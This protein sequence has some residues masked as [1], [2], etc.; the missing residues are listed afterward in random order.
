V[1][2]GTFHFGFFFPKIYFLENDNQ[3][4]YRQNQDY[5]RDLSVAR[6]RLDGKEIEVQKLYKQILEQDQTFAKS[7]RL[8]EEAFRERE[9]KMILK[10]INEVRD[11]SNLRIQQ[12]Q[13]LGEQDEKLRNMQKQIDALEEQNR[14]LTNDVKRYRDMMVN[15]FVVNYFFYL[16][17]SD[18]YISIP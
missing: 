9:E 5:E 8:Q 15:K 1:N 14:T 2:F 17:R 6:Q 7:Y 12:Q 10:L 13:K 16:T 3:I 11:Q 4:S 18:R